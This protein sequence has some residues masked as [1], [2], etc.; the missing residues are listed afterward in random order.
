[1]SSSNNIKGE[2]VRFISGSYAGMKGWINVGKECTSSRRIRVLVYRG[3]KNSLKAANVFTSSVQLESA[4]K[5]PASNAEAVLAQCPDIEKK[6]VALCN[7]FV[8]AGLDCEEDGLTQVMANYMN[9]AAKNQAKLGNRACFRK[10]NMP[11]NKSEKKYVKN[12]KM[13]A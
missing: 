9:N 8:K 4:Y 6:L 1:M 2:P 5:N 11:Y 13:K 7:A 10:V 3:E 12:E